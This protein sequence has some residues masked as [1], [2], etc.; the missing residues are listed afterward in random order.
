LRNVQ[1][2]PC[3]V[4]KVSVSG[5]ILI[6]DDDP[7]NVEVIEAFLAEVSDE[8]LGII[9]PAQA[10]RVFGEFE[11]DIVLL[12]LHMP[13]PDGF[14]LLR[15]FKD[16]RS[17]RG[18][19]PFVVLSADDESAAQDDALALG[20]DDFLTKPMRRWEVV[21]RVENLLRTRRLFLEQGKAETTTVFS[22]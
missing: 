17:R 19:V 21:L 20:A 2:L 14:E 10:E 22:G 3:T 18:Y 4:S 13:D 7:M 6:I 5:R 11:P 12:D 1:A 8:I 16:I 9:D 15:R